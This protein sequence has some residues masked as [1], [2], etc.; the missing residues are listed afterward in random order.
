[1]VEAFEGL[2]QRGLQAA[3]VFSSGFSAAG[4]EGA[5]LERRLVELA[6]AHDVALCGPNTAGVISMT[7]GFVGSFTHALADGAPQLGSLMVITESAAIGGLLLMRLRERRVCIRHWISVGNGAVLDVPDYLEYAAVDEVAS[8][9]ALFVGGINDGSRFRAAADRCRAAGKQLF[10]F[11]AGTTDDGCVLVDA[12]LRRST[13][14][15]GGVS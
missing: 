6:T 9:I 4:K 13:L 11:K 14:P 8:A 10:A 12:R 1:V 2:C 5:A 15:S 3:V 7:T